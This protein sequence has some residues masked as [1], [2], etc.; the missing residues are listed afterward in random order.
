MADVTEAERKEKLKQ[1]DREVLAHSGEGVGIIVTMFTGFMLC[2]VLSH[3]MS[4]K[5]IVVCLF[6]LRPLSE[7]V[8]FQ[9]L[10]AGL[11]GM[12]VMLVVQG[13]LFVIKSNRGISTTESKNRKATSSFSYQTSVSQNLTR[14]V[15]WEERARISLV[16]FGDTSGVG[17]HRASGCGDRTGRGR[18]QKGSVMNEYDPNRKVR[19]RKFICTELQLIIRD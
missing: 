8:H 12:I 9:H 13:L 1:E 16:H 10:S 4:D 14:C 7:T 11:F 17:S 15:F 5:P 19:T 2:F 3:Q 6:F 18:E